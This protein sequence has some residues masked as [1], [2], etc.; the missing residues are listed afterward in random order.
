MKKIIAVLLVA[1]GLLALCA[2]QSEGAGA[3]SFSKEKQQEIITAFIAENSDAKYPLKKEDISL[4]CY[5]AFDGAY[6][7]FVDV[8][9]WNYT[10]AIETDVIAGVEFVYSSGQKMT[11]YYSGKF[12]TL[13]EAYD[14][15]VLSLASLRAVQKSY[16]EG[17]E[18]L[19]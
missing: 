9:G 8:V 7:L 1:V 12:Y 2:C 6:V 18:Y 5:G 13:S 15:G 14:R 4:R 19:Y 10:M 11:V 16:K 3:N 17:H